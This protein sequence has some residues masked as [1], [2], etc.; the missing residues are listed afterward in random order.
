MTID[1]ALLDA[2]AQAELVARRELSALE[3]VDAALARIARVD[4]ELHAVASLD[5]EGARTRARSPLSGPLAGVPMLAK[6]LL[7]VKGQR[8]TFGCRL[9]AQNVAQEDAP[10]TRRLLD[11]GLVIVG[12]STTSEFGMLGST[13]TLLHGVTHNPYD[14][15]R[16]AT[17]SSG[18]SAAA[19]AAGLVPLAHASDGGG[20]IHLPASAQGLFGFKPSRRR[21]V[22]AAP[23]DMDGALSEHVVTRSVRDSALLLTLLA[24]EKA[25][26]PPLAHVRGPAKQRL[27]I[28]AYSETLFGAAPSAEVHAAYQRT[29]ALC[30]ELGHE[31][32]EG[33]GPR[34]DARALSDAFFL[35]GGFGLAMLADQLAP[36][37]G[38]PL[39][40]AEL[41]PFTLTL[42]ARARAA[43][44]EGLARAQRALTKARADMAAFLS[45]A[46][47]T[48]CPTTPD[49]VPKLGELA[50]T[51]DYDQLIARTERFAGYTAIHNTVGAPAMSVPLFTE[52]GGLPIGSHFAAPVGEDARLLALAYELEAAQ[53]WAQRRP[54][55]HA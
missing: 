38:H 41:E 48:L 30:R 16:S 3:L 23:D 31:V 7:N 34:I 35:I 15:A 32:E 50:P 51:R 17:G 4:P 33:P 29:V 1:L 52:P 27:R 13:E 10:L 49:S 24:D 40:E 53:P 14:P 42:I 8:C 46:D 43:G 20:S 19:V 44:S 6:D 28:A 37:V 54:P 21:H 9:F 11:A 47:V 22:P 26:L 18:G 12:K 55:V 36:M 5:A 25:A 39:G 45:Q 2:T